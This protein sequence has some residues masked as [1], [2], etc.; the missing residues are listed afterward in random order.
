MNGKQKTKRQS[1]ASNIEKD[2]VHDRIKEPPMYKV[3]LH[4]DDITPMDTVVHILKTIF[5]KS[6]QEA[7]TLMLTIHNS[8][9]G[10]VGIYTRD[11]AETKILQTEHVAQCGNYPLK[12]TIEQV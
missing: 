9:S 8:H 4:N 7:V 1:D 11:I 12:V 10:A 3:F 2:I 5:N 6:D